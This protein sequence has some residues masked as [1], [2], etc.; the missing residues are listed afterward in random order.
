MIIAG[1]YDFN[2]IKNDEIIQFN[3]DCITIFK[4]K[5]SKNYDECF[6]LNKESFSKLVAITTNIND[7]TLKGNRVSYL[8]DK[9]KYSTPI[10][11]NPSLDL[12]NDVF[13]N[14]PRT[15][16]VNLDKLV[17]ASKQVDVDNYRT[18][19]RGVIIKINE[20]GDYVI[21]GADNFR[22]YSEG[23]YQNIDT[24]K[25][26]VDAYSIPV[27]FIK[28]INS[29]RNKISIKDDVKLSFNENYV[30]VELKETKSLNLRDITIYSR[31]Y[32]GGTAD[33][34]TLELIEKRYGIGE[35]T[36][37]PS[38]LT[39]VIKDGFVDIEINP[40][41]GIKFTFKSSFDELMIIYSCDS[42]NEFKGKFQT[43]L[44]LDNLL[45]GER[46]HLI[47]GENMIKLNGV[48]VLKMVER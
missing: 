42:E 3:R 25:Y 8:K 40:E 45:I 38:N 20:Y 31:L 4:Q 24:N 10:V 23:N 44:I 36:F 41:K 26:K 9:I 27:S 43:S 46:N 1:N 30:K 48:I 28:L 47:L 16:I 19:Y 39:N 11:D 37:T 32:N 13:K 14:F 17:K 2:V 21:E 33:F 35:C 29:I 15:I 18:A 6:T 7:L 22:I 34:S 5:L 12:D